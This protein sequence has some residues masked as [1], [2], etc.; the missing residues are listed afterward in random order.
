MNMARTTRRWDMDTKRY[1]CLSLS[2][3]PRRW[4]GGGL[5]EFKTA[6]KIKLQKTLWTSLDNVIILNLGNFYDN[7]TN[8]ACF[9]LLR[10]WRDL[11]KSYFDSTV[12]MDWANQQISKFTYV[13]SFNVCSKNVSLMKTLDLYDMIF[14]TCP[15]VIHSSLVGLEDEEMAPESLALEAMIFDNDQGF[16]GGLWFQPTCLSFVPPT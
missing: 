1:W 11:R 3:L 4:I 9:R 10:I 5:A 7:W 12:W 16:F 6:W 15:L 2:T 8:N 13:D 14:I